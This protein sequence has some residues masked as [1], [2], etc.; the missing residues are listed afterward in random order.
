MTTQSEITQ[1]PN[2]R[3]LHHNAQDD[4]WVTI[5]SMIHMV[6]TRATEL[7]MSVLNGVM[8]VRNYKISR[9]HKWHL[10]MFV[11]QE[12][13]VTQ[14]FWPNLEVLHLTNYNPTS[15]M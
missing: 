5:Q 14:Y 6:E 2:D 3:L 9:T 8:Q 10:E 11:R 7:G 4:A 1:T 12:T 15:R 13:F